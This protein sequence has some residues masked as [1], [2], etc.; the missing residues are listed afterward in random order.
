MTV[1]I[2]GNPSA[3]TAGRRWRSAFGHL[4]AYA[5][6]GTEVRPGDV[7]GSGTCGGGCLAELWAATASRR[8]RGE[9]PRCGLA[10]LPAVFKPRGRQLVVEPVCLFSDGGEEGAERGGVGLS[11]VTTINRQLMIA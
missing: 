7:L 11:R 3:R 4:V 1:E 10:L 5:S 6:R 2:N 9:H 8:R